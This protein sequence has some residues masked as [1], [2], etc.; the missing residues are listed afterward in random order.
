LPSFHLVKAILF[1][2]WL[3]LSFTSLLLIYFDEIEKISKI[4]YKLVMES[5]R[6]RGKNNPCKSIMDV[7]KE[8]ELRE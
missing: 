6:E 1:P 4:N 8:K 3:C 2:L 7:E 5:G